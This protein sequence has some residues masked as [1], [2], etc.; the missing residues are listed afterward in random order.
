MV[1]VTTSA[2]LQLWH[3][4]M[5]NTAAHQQ[6]SLPSLAMKQLEE[7]AVLPTKALVWCL[8]V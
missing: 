8:V 2:F 3:A 5:V 6:Q 1:K 4:Q 7:T